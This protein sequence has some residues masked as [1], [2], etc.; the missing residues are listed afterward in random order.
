MIYLYQFI[1]LVLVWLQ[2]PINNIIKIQK[3]VRKFLI[4]KN[5]LI[6]SSYYQTK[7]WRKNRYWYNGG[8]YNECEKYQIKLIE[9]ILKININKTHE[10]L[11]IENLTI[12]NI[13][14]PL[15][16][17]NGYEFTENF[18]GKI[19]INNK[20]YYFNLKFV[21][22]N[23]GAQNR[24]LREVYHFIKT[25]I[26]YLINNNDNNIYFINILDGDTCYNNQNK[27]NYLFL[28]KKIE[29]IFVGDIY[30]FQKKKYLFNL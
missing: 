23:G 9:K 22:D 30:T 4:K 29:N 3:I 13:K 6:S 14:Y 8:K 11:N 28:N 24:T 25:Q 16:N 19:T 15:K 5:I 20:I 27:F 2:P 26:K 17:N 21:C 12:M 1:L 7:Q 18:D 10:R